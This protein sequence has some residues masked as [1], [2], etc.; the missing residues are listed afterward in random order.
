M[1]SADLDMKSVTSAKFDDKANSTSLKIGNHMGGYQS[2]STAQKD[3]EFKSK[4]INKSNNKI[5]PSENYE[6]DSDYGWEEFEALEN[7]EQRKDA[8]IKAG[9]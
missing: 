7:F 8:L 5:L 2:D 9:V 1:L 3:F 6:N 4:L